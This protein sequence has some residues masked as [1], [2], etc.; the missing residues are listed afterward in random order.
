M[1]EIFSFLLSIGLIAL[2]V[3]LLVG[4]IRDLRESKRDKN[5]NKKKGVKKDDN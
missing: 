2:I 5:K 3:W 4:F 1:K